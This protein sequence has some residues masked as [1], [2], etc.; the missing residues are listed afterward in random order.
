[1]KNL[2]KR[3]LDYRFGKAWLLPVFLLMPGIV[4]DA[5]LLSILSGEPTRDLSSL[6]NLVIPIALSMYSFWE[7]RFKKNLVGEGML[8]IIL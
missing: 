3:G 4:G 7:D 1:V 6:S 8:S 5:L 2:L